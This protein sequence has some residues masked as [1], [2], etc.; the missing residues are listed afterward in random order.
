MEATVVF[1]PPS[2]R[3]KA[4]LVSFIVLPTSD[5]VFDVL[6]AEVPDVSNRFFHSIHALI[7]FLD[8]LEA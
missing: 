1:I 4:V 5:T 8:G 3:L 7:D 6:V 2:V